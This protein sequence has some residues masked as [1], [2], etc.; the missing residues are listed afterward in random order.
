[1]AKTNLVRYSRAGDV[2]HY[3]WAARRCLKLINPKSPLEFIIIEGS[4]ERHRAGEYIIDVAEYI[5]PIDDNSGGIS[6]YQLKHSTTRKDQQFQLSDLKDTIEG[7]A[8]RYSDHNK[9]DSVGN[10]PIEISFSI[11][12]NRPIAEKFKQN[13]LDLSHGKS[14]SE[15][16]Q[17]RLRNTQ[18]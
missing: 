9:D 6:Y 4:K 11:V 16:F 3:R 7:F 8:N 12:T 15:R 1:M 13:I 14:V 5:A 10:G 17:K 2:F 18:N